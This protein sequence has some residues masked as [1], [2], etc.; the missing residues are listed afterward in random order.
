MFSM[1]LEEIFVYL[2]LRKKYSHGYTVMEGRYMLGTPTIHFGAC[3]SP[4]AS[5]FSK[6]TSAMTMAWEGDGDQELRLLSSKNLYCT[7]R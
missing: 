3:Q 7:T 2:N 1:A 4:L 6:S 5:F